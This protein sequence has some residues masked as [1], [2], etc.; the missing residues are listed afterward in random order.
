[1]T[2]KQVYVGFDCSS[3]AIHGVLLDTD[4]KLLHQQKWASS[5]DTYHERFLEITA[6]FWADNSRIKTILTESKRILAAVEAAIY[7]QNPH[8]TLAIASVVGCVDFICN[9]SGFEVV[10]IDNRKWK[11]ELLGKGNATKPDILKF[12]KDKW[13]DV[14]EEQDFADAACIALWRKQKED[15]DEK[16]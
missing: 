13:G 10:L 5:K 3:K 7:I 8:T 2:N 15:L 12:A 11:K 14:F 1:M 6:N 16:S 9:Q 4:G